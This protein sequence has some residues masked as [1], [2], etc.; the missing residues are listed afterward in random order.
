MQLLRYP[1][2]RAEQIAGRAG[3]DPRCRL[4]QP[5]PAVRHLSHAA[6]GRR[7]C[8]DDQTQPATDRARSTRRQPRPQRT[9]HGRDQLSVPVLAAGFGRLSRLDRLR[10]QAACDDRS[11]PWMAE[12]ACRLEERARGGLKPRPDNWRRHT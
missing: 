12:R 4:G 9:G 8:G 7:T 6:H 11:R 1:R 10:I 5:V 2:L 3:C